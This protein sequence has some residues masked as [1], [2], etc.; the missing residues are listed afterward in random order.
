MAGLGL[1]AFKESPLVLA[2]VVVQWRV[3]WHKYG[4]DRFDN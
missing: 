3:Y 2:I 1:W 4:Y